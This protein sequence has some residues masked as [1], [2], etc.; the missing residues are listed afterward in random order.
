EASMVDQTMMTRLTQALSPETQLVLLGDKDQLASVEAGAVLGDIC[1]NATENKFTISAND[2][3]ESL[4]IK[5]N[6][7]HITSDNKGFINHINLLKKSYRFTEH[8][9]IGHL[10]E[11]I[12][13]GNLGKAVQ[14]LNSD[15]HPDI[16][17]TG[18]DSY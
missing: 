12:H 1:G 6:E 10:V 18:F 8:S 17:F 2:Y 9:G 5:L 14:L 16:T 7:K 4:D 15:E 13:S 3:L 11:A